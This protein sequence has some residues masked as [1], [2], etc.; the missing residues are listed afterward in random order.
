[1]AKLTNYTYC[2]KKKGVLKEEVFKKVIN[3]T[4]LDNIL[5]LLHYSATAYALDIETLWLC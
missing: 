1:M 2:P 5:Y 3:Y 4:T